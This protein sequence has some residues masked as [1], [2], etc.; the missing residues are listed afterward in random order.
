MLVAIRRMRIILFNIKDGVRACKHTC[1]LCTSLRIL[2]SSGPSKLILPDEDAADTDSSPQL[3][4]AHTRA[5][6][7]RPTQH[8]LAL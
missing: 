6:S 1:S 8:T 5:P 4:H 7:P 2:I 3:A